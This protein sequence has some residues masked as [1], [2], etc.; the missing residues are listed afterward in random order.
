VSEGASLGGAATAPTSPTGPLIGV[1]LGPRT[2]P[3]LGAVVAAVVLAW[4][5]LQTATELFRRLF[6][7]R[8]KVEDVWGHVTG[9]RLASHGNG[10]A[11]YDISTQRA[12]QR[13][14]RGPDADRD[15][16]AYLYPPHLT[17][18]FRPLARFE[19]L[20]VHRV[21]LVLN[22]VLIGAVIW[23][24]NHRFR[25][26]TRA[27]RVVASLFAASFLPFW[28]SAYRGQFAMLYVCACF[29]LLWAAEQ[30]RPWVGAVM[31]LALSWKPPLAAL[32][33]L[34]MIVGRRTRPMVWRFVVLVA[35]SSAFA[36]WWLGPEAFTGYLRITRETAA[37]DG[38]DVLTINVMAT[39]RSLLESWGIGSGVA[40][41]INR[42]AFLVGVAATVLVFRSNRLPVARQLATVLAIGAATTLY[43]Y[44]YDL[45]VT[46]V[47][48]AVLWDV[49]RG[50][51][52]RTRRIVAVGL[53][54]G[55]V[56]L[57]S[58]VQLEA[59][60]KP[61]VLAMLALASTWLVLLRRPVTARPVA[62]G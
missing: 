49:V 24:L 37:V 57:V 22:V 60:G 5:A 62:S 41:S 10:A 20:G 4:T 25:T 28:Y 51:T 13:S 16:L 36:L 27:E 52:L 6:G 54:V 14:L 1:R 48:I 19:P 12:L 56:L 47:S 50:A 35:T 40:V 45:A 34:G 8:I 58:S 9:W 42:A 3:G 29:G 2:R 38:A 32:L 18:F 39:I 15:L 44:P 17:P 33:V 7:N 31:L 55:N 53:V 23:W 11:L 43:Q 26:W 59:L 21:L 46:A 30:D 61:S